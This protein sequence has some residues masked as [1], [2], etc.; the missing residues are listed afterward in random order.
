LAQNFPRAG[1]K[2]PS[3]LSFSLDSSLPAPIAKDT[4]FV[5]SL[6]EK[7]NERIESEVAESLQTRYKDLGIKEKLDQLDE[8][9]RKGNKRDKENDAKENGKEEEGS[10]KK[11]RKAWYGKL[12][13]YR[14]LIVANECTFSIIRRPSGTAGN[15]QAAH[16]VSNVLDRLKS[17]QSDLL[18]DIKKE[19]SEL[20]T[21]VGDVKK[22]VDEGEK[23]IRQ[24]RR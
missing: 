18:D 3:L 16:D 9:C 24:G 1:K 21:K 15:D 20:H 5:S 19:I 14:N 11:R 2:S 23:E 17:I 8:I 4:K 6:Q 7:L 22:E 12:K 13:M 10:D